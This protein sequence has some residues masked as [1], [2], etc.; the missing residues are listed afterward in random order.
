MLCCLFD[1]FCLPYRQMVRLHLATTSLLALMALQES[2][3]TW[4]TTPTKYQSTT[5]NCGLIVVLYL[6]C[7]TPSL[8]HQ[9]RACAVYCTLELSELLKLHY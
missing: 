9:S 5:F 2:P 7:C 8:L 3:S 1:F 6:L 4:L